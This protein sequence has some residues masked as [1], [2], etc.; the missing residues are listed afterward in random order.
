MLQ[1]AKIKT[2]FK[3][4]K[5]VIVCLLQLVVPAVSIFFIIR[6]LNGPDIVASVLTLLVALPTAASLALMAEQFRGDAASDS[7]AGEIVALSTILSAATLPI[8]VT[9]LLG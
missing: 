1:R 9:V 8:I 6:L 3:R 2:L 5:T 4:W 7:K